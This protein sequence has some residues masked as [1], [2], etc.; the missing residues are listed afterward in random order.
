[1]MFGFDAFPQFQ[2]AGLAFGSGDEQ[3]RLGGVKIILNETTGQLQPP[4]EEL[5]RQVLS[6]HR[7]GFQLA[8]TFINNL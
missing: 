5:N 7:A 2:Q 1:M 4:P 6:S 8:M 3:L